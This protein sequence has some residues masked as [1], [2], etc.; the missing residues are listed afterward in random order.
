MGELVSVI[1]PIYNGEKYL[2]ECLDSIVNQTYSNLDICLID[3]G[4][5]D[6]SEEICRHYAVADKRVR[7]VRQNNQGCSAARN[8]GIKIS[9]GGGISFL[10]I[11]MILL[12]L[13]P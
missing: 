12:S 7:Y 9:R 8:K 6:R 4:S 1:V 5:T 2:S 13:R 10:L 3:D 11:V